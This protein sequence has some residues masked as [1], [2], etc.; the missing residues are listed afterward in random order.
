MSEAP[1][2]APPEPA[3]PIPAGVLAEVEAALAKALQAQANFAARAPAVRNAIEAARNSA[4]GSDRWAGAQVALSE[5]DS[6]RASTA[7]ALGELD[8]LYAARA[9]QLE[10]RDAIGE[11]REQITRLLA[12]QDAVLAALKP[13]LRQ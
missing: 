8:V 4:V 3:E 5:L 9:V 7:I 1:N 12:R 10:R 2:P 13:I 11:A 6:L